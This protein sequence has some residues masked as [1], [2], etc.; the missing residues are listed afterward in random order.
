ML[1][2]LNKIAASQAKPTIHTKLDTDMLLN[3]VHMYPNAKINYHDRGTI[4]H[5]KSY[6]AYLVMPGS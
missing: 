3:N 2:E 6:E 4:L 5:I 1:P